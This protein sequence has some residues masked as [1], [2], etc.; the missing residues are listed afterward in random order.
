VTEIHVQ[1]C[2][3]TPEIRAL[4]DIAQDWINDYDLVVNDDEVRDAIAASGATMIGFREL[5]TLMRSR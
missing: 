2:I 3:D 5:R 4:G 1:P